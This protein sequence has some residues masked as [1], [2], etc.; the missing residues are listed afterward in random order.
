MKD[1]LNTLCESYTLEGLAKV[2]I[3]LEDELEEM[4]QIANKNYD[5]VQFYENLINERDE[6]IN[7]QKNDI[8]KLESE[9]DAKDEIIK[10]LKIRKIISVIVAKEINGVVYVTLDDFIETVNGL[11][12][13]QYETDNQ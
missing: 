8:A 6:H 5:R 3:K 4:K 10:H 1:R 9:R 11:M 12:E 13:K 2:C 7:K